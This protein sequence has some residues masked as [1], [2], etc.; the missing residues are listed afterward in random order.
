MSM[1]A[2]KMKQFSVQLPLKVVRVL[3]DL[4]RLGL[5]SSRAECIR[6]AIHDLVMEHVSF[7]HYVETY[8]LHK[9][10]TQLEAV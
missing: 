2:I 6:M 3:D 1:N 7:G 8:N 5:Y 10:L 4:V 9:T